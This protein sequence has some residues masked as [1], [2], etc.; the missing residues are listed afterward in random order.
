MGRVVAIDG[1]G[2]GDITKT[3]EIWRAD[4]IAVGFAA[5][6]V[7]D[8]RVYV[9]DNAANLHALDQKTGKP[10]WTHNLGTIGRAAPMFA[11][12]KLFADRGERQGADRG[13][14]THRRAHAPRRG[15]H[16]ARGPL[17]GGL[18]LGG[19]RLRPPLLH[20]RGRALLHRPQGRA[21]QGRARGGEGRRRSRRRRGRQGRAL[22]VVPGRGDR[23]ARASAVAVR[24][25]VVR[26]QG[27]LP[28]QG[29]GR[30]GAS[31]ACG[32]RST[33]TASSPRPGPPPRRAR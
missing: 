29:E 4:G 21:V 2:T 23:V 9:V 28:A 27:P 30:P 3:G 15:A 18:G 7:A 11:D 10:L 6:T 19:G 16:D 31:R 5:P 14:G 25:L 13:A 24:G 26:R 22:L 32:R 20:G 1:K 33:P 12:G 17:R 8:G